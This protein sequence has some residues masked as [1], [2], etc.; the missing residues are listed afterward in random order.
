MVDL[1]LMAAVLEALPDSAPLVLIGDAHQLPAVDA[2]KIL[3]DLAS[4]NLGGRACV[5]TLEHSHRMDAADPRGRQVLDTARAIHR[6]EGQ[7]ITDRH[8]PLAVARTPGTLTFSGSE[9]VDAVPE[10]TTARA[11][12]AALWHRYGG[13]QANRIAND[14]VFR[15]EA[16]SV[17]AEQASDLE[18]LW[19][20]LTQARLLTV[21]RGL[22]TGSI[23]LNAYLHQLALDRMTL[24][25]TPEFV[26]GEPVMIT[27]NDYQR[28]LWNGDQGMIIRAEETL[29]PSAAPPPS[30]Q[31]RHHRYR[32]LFRTG[33]KLVPFAIEA[34]RDRIELAWALTIHKSQG[35]EF[36]AVAMVLPD[37]D[38]PLLTRELIYTGIT[39]ARTS[40]VL[41]GSR[42]AIHSAAKRVAL[43]HSGLADR[44]R[45]TVRGS[46]TRS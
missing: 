22:P 28:G 37:D 40:V 9:W 2:G 18:A 24:V 42:T 36:D 25:A 16:G 29:G 15:F 10:G 39:R 31:G 23:A 38:L 8:E 14:T 41:C 5:A 13:A 34:L 6:G 43:R 20:L 12:A 27:A 4:L 32:A 45:A 35:S 44:I 26:P 46:P 33:G 17:V 3:S 1:D 30:R 11:V 7:R 21:T 19:S